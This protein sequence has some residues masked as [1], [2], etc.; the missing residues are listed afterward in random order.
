MVAVTHTAQQIIEWSTA[1]C[2][3]SLAFSI[4]QH[5]QLHI[6]LLA[7]QH[8]VVPMQMATEGTL[9]SGISTDTPQPCILRLQS[10]LHLASFHHCFGHIIS[11]V[12]SWYLMTA[13]V[14]LVL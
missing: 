1:V 10:R 4:V 2:N 6:F 3:V 9:E 14:F 5:Y 7:Q 12:Y 13:T 11:K 8:A